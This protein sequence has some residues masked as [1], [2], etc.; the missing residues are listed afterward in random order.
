MPTSQEENLPHQEEKNQHRE[1]IVALVIK[2]VVDDA[3]VPPVQ[4]AHVGNSEPGRDEQK[5]IQRAEGWRLHA[6]HFSYRLEELGIP[7]CNAME[8]KWAET[9]VFLRDVDVAR[10][11]RLLVKWRCA[12][13]ISP[14]FAV[15]EEKCWRI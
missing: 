11:R 13:Y 15:F 8:N 5:I 10:T 3:V 2:Q 12:R 4:V 7:E 1:K 6:C 9:Q 14:R